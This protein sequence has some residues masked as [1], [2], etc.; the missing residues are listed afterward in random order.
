MRA[1][2]ANNRNQKG[3]WIKKFL[4]VDV[5]NDSA[6]ETVNAD[7]KREKFLYRNHAITGT[8]N[9]N[10]SIQ[11]LA[12]VIL[13]NQLYS[14]GIFYYDNTLFD[15]IKCI[16]IISDRWFKLCEFHQVT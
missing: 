12:N 13:S 6:V 8:N 16:V 1:A 11:M 5:E 10:G 14:I 9:K 3:S 4:L 15:G 2:N 7:F